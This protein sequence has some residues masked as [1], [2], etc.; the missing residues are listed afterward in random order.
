MA[1]ITP[2]FGKGN[3][4]TLTVVAGLDDTY[5]FQIKVERYTFDSRMELED[6]SGYGDGGASVWE[7]T[8]VLYADF[9]VIGRMITNGAVDPAS[10]G[11]TISSAN[12]K[13]HGDT[14]KNAA[15]VKVSRMRIDQNYTKNVP[16]MLWGKTTGTITHTQA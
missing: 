2:T 9:I 3:S 5:T 11:T 1:A 14:V 7:D 6:V 16:I 4:G 10:L 15:D 13:L 12:F 8:G